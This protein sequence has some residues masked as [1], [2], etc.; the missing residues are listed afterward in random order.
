MVIANRLS[1]RK[2]VKLLGNCGLL[3][4]LALFSSTAMATSAS[5]LTIG[6]VAS[7][8]TGSFTQI[9]KLITAASYLAGLGFSIG[10]IM[11][12][13]QHK[14]NPT[15]I[16]IGTPIALL[17]IAA[18]LLFLPSILDITSHT[19]FGGSGGT[20]AGPTGTVFD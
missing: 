15:Q 11:K 4:F 17:F 20:V 5:D 7:L 12:F 16:P 1:R 19:M 10:A 2:H 8:I 13:K 6:D 18:A 9:A 3:A 14:D